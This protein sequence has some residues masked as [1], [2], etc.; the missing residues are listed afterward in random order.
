[1][2]QR[3]LLPT[4]TPAAP[5]AGAKPLSEDLLRGTS[6][7]RDYLG[8]KDDKQVYR[9]VEAN[10]RRP[11]SAPPILKDPTGLV[12]RK[13]AIDAWYQRAETATQRP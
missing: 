4:L 7:I 6:E 3:P 5:A 13:S 10:K 8:L 12:A 2:A 1:M 11:G 9:L